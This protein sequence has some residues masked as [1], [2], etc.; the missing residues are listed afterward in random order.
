[1]SAWLVVQFRAYGLKWISHKTWKQVIQIQIVIFFDSSSYD[2]MGARAIPVDEPLWR[3]EISRH[4][5]PI[6]IDPFDFFVTH[7]QCQSRC[8]IAPI[9]NA[10]L[11][12]NA[13][14]R[15]LLI[16]FA[17]IDYTFIYAHCVMC[18]T[19]LGLVTSITSMPQWSGCYGHVEL[20]IWKLFRWILWHLHHTIFQFVHSNERLSMLVFV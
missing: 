19:S 9:V 12:W 17:N 16:K 18:C 1:M 20:C 10:T 4:V 13:C 14:I 3:S 5:G 11:F 8:D 15:E 7:F 2:K 6:V